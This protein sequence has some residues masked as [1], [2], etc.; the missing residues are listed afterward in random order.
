MQGKIMLL[1]SIT[2]I[3]AHTYQR[4]KQIRLK[5]KT[6]RRSQ[7]DKRNAAEKMYKQTMSIVMKEDHFLCETQNTS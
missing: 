4:K 1:I 3:K 6:T 7:L 5:Y 2:I